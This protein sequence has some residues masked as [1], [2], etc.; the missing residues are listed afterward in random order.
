[1]DKLINSKKRSLRNQV[2][3]NEIQLSTRRVQRTRAGNRLDQV[4]QEQLEDPSK[5][6]GVRSKRGLE[7]PAPKNEIDCREIVQKE[8]KQARQMR[9]KF[10]RRYTSQ[11][12]VR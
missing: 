1:M 11:Q 5:L 2:I 12:S 4:L 8:L 6:L 3:L 9:Q 10:E 7:E